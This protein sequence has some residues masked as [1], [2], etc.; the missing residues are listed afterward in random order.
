MF[1]G[2]YRE[3]RDIKRTPRRPPTIWSDFFKKALNERNV[4]PRVHEAR[5]IH[6]TTLARDRDEWRRCWR[7]LDE[8]DD[9]WDDRKVFHKTASTFP[10]LLINN[11]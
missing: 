10:T 3:N 4:G 9:Q 11:E 1:G 6:W 8:I 5:T 2:Q 7:L